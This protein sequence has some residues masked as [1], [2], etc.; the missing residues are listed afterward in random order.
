VRR[1]LPALVL[2]FVAAVF[3]WG[4]ALDADGERLGTPLPP[5][6]FDVHRQ[7]APPWALLAAA[8]LAAGVAAAPRLR[9]LPSWAFGLALLGLALAT[10]LA[11][12]AARLGPEGWDE[13]FH[14]SFEAKNEYLPALRALEHG[15]G[16]FLDRFAE[17]VPALP[18]HAAG[19][20]PGLV[21]ALHWLGI[22]SPGG[23]SAL[24]IAVAAIGVPLTWLLARRL[25]DEDRART[26]GVLAAFASATT[27]YGVTSA[28]AAF[29]ALGTGTAVLLLS[30]PRVAALAGAAALA[31][32][33]FFS[34]ALLAIGAWAAL[35]RLGR[36]GWRTALAIA[37]ACG[38]A[39]VVFYAALW[40]LTGFELPD[41]LAATEET[42][43]A[44]VARL[45]PYWFWVLGSP[46]AFL[47]FLGVPVVWY[48]A[49]AVG[50]RRPEALALAA[51]LVVSAAGGFTKAE[52]ERIWLMY[53]PLA[54]VA[55]AAVLPPRRLPLVLALLAVQSLVVELVFGTVW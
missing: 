12:G 54:C 45:R 32:A 31:V 20:P 15:A 37:T 7:I 11:V 40:A 6:L 55:A 18:I 28:D 3:A 53:V 9:T 19:H 41:V 25:L 42:Y 30:A 14:E 10:R 27:L 29:A 1:V 43:R 22:D 50:E 38:V 39:L 48:A 51:V 4:L 13:P 16:W 49:R 26:A 24:V 52:T 17:L 47:A 33:S 23:A 2:A 46:A 36:D 21:L 5:L 44:S 35:V 8:L 34:Y